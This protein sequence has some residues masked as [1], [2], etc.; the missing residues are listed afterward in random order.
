[1]GLARE[2]SNPSACVGPAVFFA[3]V[4]MRLVIVNVVASAQAREEAAMNYS[5]R[6]N[7]SVLETVWAVGCSVMAG[8]LPT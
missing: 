5:Q 3:L 7:V 1:M 8:S 2:G 6:V 4:L